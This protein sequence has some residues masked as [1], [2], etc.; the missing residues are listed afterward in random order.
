[1]RQF[2]EAQSATGREALFGNLLL[3]LF[4]CGVLAF[5]VTVDRVDWLRIRPAS[6]SSAAMAQA[7]AAPEPVNRP[8]ISGTAEQGVDHTP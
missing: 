3:F 5:F 7:V 2:S 4:G 6:A 8:G 1:M